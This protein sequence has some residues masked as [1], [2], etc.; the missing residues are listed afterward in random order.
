MDK[1]KRFVSFLL[2]FVMILGF[3]PV[4]AFATDTAA[5]TR[6]AID[7]AVFF[8][9]LHINNKQ[10]ETDSKKTL[11]TDVLTAIKNAD[12]P[13]STVNSS[14]DMYSSNASNEMV[15]GNASQVTGWIN[16][17][18]S[19][20]ETNYVW[21]DHDRAATDISK[22]SYMVDYDNYY[23]YVLSMGDLSSNDRYSTG[24]AYTKN[25]NTNRVKSGFSEGVFE[26]IAEFEADVSKLDK[27]K[28]LFI[29]GHQ[30]L[31]DNRNDNA[32]AE[33]WVEAINKVA[34]EMDVTYFFGHNHKYDLS[35][36]QTNG[37]DYYFAKGTKMPVPEWDDWTKA[38]NGDYFYN[39]GTQNG[40]PDLGY[41][42]VEIN[43]TH[44]CAGYMNP[45][46]TKSYDSKTSRLGTAVVAAIYD[47]CITYTVYDKD[48]VYDSNAKMALDVTVER[49]NK[50]T[51]DG[52]GSGETTEP[53]VTVEPV[54]DIFDSGISVAASG[55]TEVA[56]QE[57]LASEYDATRYTAYASYNIEVDGGYVE[58]TEA[59]VTIPAPVGFDVKKAVVVLDMDR[60]GKVIATTNIVDGKITFT[61][62][63]FSTYD[64]AQL[65]E[66]VEPSVLLNGWHLV[67]TTP[68]D[69][70][71]TYNAGWITFQ[72]YVPEVPATEKNKYVLDSDGVDTNV[73]YLIV[74]TGTNGSG[75]A[76]TNSSGKAA[77]TVVEIANGEILVNKSET[78]N[79]VWRFSG[80]TSGNVSNGG[81][82]LNPQNSSLSLSTS[83]TSSTSLTF[84]SQK[85][86][87]YRIYRLDGG[88]VR[89]TYYWISYDAAN[90]KWT[91]NSASVYHLLGSNS[92]I[93]TAMTSVHL[94][95]Y[96]STVTTEH[97]PAVP[98]LYGKIAIADN[99]DMSVTVEHGT[100]ME[101]AIA[102]LQAKV[103][104]A[105]KTSPD[106]TV[107]TCADSD[108]VWTID[109][110]Y[111]GTVGGD[112]A[113][114]ISYN[115]VTLGIGEVV[116]ESV[117]AY[118]GA[119][120]PKNITVEMGTSAGMAL[121][122][123]KQAVTIYSATTSNGDNSTPISDSSVTWEWVDEYNASRPGPY[124][125]EIKAGDNL[126][127]EV[128]VHVHVSYGEDEGESNEVEVGDVTIIEKTVYMLTNELVDGEEYLIVNKKTEGS[129]YALQNNNNNNGS[130]ASTSVDVNVDSNGTYIELDNADAVLWTAT[131]SGNTWAFKNGSYYLN[132]K[133]STSSSIGITTYSYSLELNGSSANWTVSDNQVYANLF[134]QDGWWSDEYDDY[135]LTGGSSWSMSRNSANVYFYIP[136]PIT[137]IEGEGVTYT[138]SASDLEHYV[139][140]DSKEAKLSYALLANGNVADPLPGSADG[141]DFKPVNDKDNIIDHIDAD[142]TIHFTGATGSALVRVSYTLDDGRQVYKYVTVTTTAPDN[143]PQYSNEGAVKVN[144]TGSAVGNFQSTGIAQVEISAS[145]VPKD[146]GMDIILML[147][148]SSSMQR[149]ITCGYKSNGCTGD[150][151]NT[152][153]PHSFVSRFDELKE[154][155]GDLEDV[156]KA[157]PNADIKI[158][159]ADFNGF[160][161]SGPYARDTD[162][163][164]SDDTVLNATGKG[165]V[166]NPATG[167]TCEIGANA[168]VSVDKIDFDKIIANTSAFAPS[169]GTNYDY[170]FDVIYQLGHAIKKANG[171]NQREL[172]VIFMSDG[173]PNQYNY[174]HSIGSETASEDESYKWNKWLQGTFASSD[175]TTSNLKSDTHKHYY[176]LKDHD[177][178]GYI[179]E[180]RMA[181]AIKGDP[182][183][184][185]E[186]VR[187]SNEGLTD[188][189][190]T[191]NSNNLYEIPGLGATMYSVGFYIKNDGKITAKSVHHV[192]E[193]IANTP[194]KY[195]T[196]S[197]AGALSKVFTNIST[198][199]IYSAYNARY[200][201]QMGK[202][203]DLQMKPLTDLDG[204]L[205]D[206]QHPNSR[207]EVIEYDVYTRADF[208]SG[209][210]TEDQIGD[211]KGTKKVLETV[212]FEYELTTGANGEEVYTV[213][214][215]YS[216]VIGNKNI[217]G[218][219]GII[220]AKNFY[221]N[222]TSKPV[223]I[224]GLEIPTGVDEHNLTT[225]STNILPA[226]SFYWGLGTLK[227]TELALR[228][229]VYLTGSMEGTRAAGTYPTNTYANL[230]Y[231]NH[232]GNPC[233]KDTV[234]PVMP[235]KEATVS[236][237]FYL[238]DENG[239]IIVNQ[240]TGDIG[241]FANKVA[242]TNPVQYST[243]KLNADGSID[244]AQ[245]AA[246]GVLPEGYVLYDAVYDANGNVLSG[247][248]Y[249][250]AVDSDGSGSWVITGPKDDDTT[251]VTQFD[252][253]NSTAY[254]NA[255]NYGQ[256]G[257]DY[258]H[259]VVW[260]AVVWKIQPL[261]DTVV[262]DYGLPVDIS[263][264]VNDMFGTNGKLA[265]VGKLD[266]PG[267]D[268]D[269]HTATNVLST[270]PCELTYGIAT[271]NTA[272]GKVRYSLNSM[273]M[274][275]H[276]QF[277]Y[278]VQYTGSENAG[279]YYETVTVIP[280][281]T[282][283]YEDSFM[284]YESF[285]W[286]GNDW[287]AFVPKDVNGDD[288]VDDSLWSVQGTTQDAVQ[289]EDR[290]G[291]YA[292]T[293]A[294]NIY[295]YDGVN[296]NMSTFS[297]GSAHKATVDG[298]NYASAEFSFYGTGFDIISMTDSTTGTILVDI[299]KENENGGWDEF[300]FYAVDTYYGY[301]Y[302]DCHVAYS[303]DACEWDSD[304]NPTAFKWVRTAIYHATSECTDKCAKQIVEQK[305]D[306]PKEYQ[307]VHMVEGAWV[308]CATEN[309][310]YQ[311]P[312]IKM[313]N[314]D[315]GHY[316]V[317]IKALYDIFFD[318]GKPAD[319][320]Y[321]FYLDAIRI[322][323]PAN[324]GAG[325]SVIEEAYKADH[326]GW[327]SYI[328]LRNGLIAAGSFD[329]VAN[330]V[331]DP[332]Q[333]MTGLVFI[334]G[335]S[336]LGNEQIADYTSYGPNNEVYIAPGQRVAFLLDTPENIDKVHI[337]LSVATAGTTAT[338]TITNI[339]L[340]DNADGK[341]TG[342]YYNYK[343]FKLDTATDMY[344][345]LTDWKGDIIVIS[346][347]GN[348]AEN[349]TTGVI[350]VTNIKS[351][352]KTNP[353]GND[354]GVVAP[355][356][357][358]ENTTE[359]ESQNLTRIYMTPKA[360]DV[361]LET[362]NDQK[363]VQ[364]PEVPVV[365]EEPEVPE[366]TEVFE[367][368]MVH[369]KLNKDEIK[370]GQ[371]VL[372]TVTTS[373]DVEYV[374]INGEKITKFSGG[375]SGNRTWKLNVVGERVGNMTVE[376]VC[377]N[378]KGIE[379][380]VLTAKVKVKAKNLVGF[381]GDI[382]G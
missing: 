112:Y 232:A 10:E 356:K 23:V 298:N 138:M 194:D 56:V 91:G 31:F 374:I 28:P 163:H 79:M 165:S 299:Y 167:A 177:G 342:D 254:S 324:D 183:K 142:G 338:Y 367:P 279:Y 128:E 134:Y 58:D 286:A 282:I 99:S 331:L 105:Y 349:E 211:R 171:D 78:A 275:T 38:G 323:D 322:Y 277:A 257:K 369:V 26:A 19:D 59:V 63:H 24:F 296:L 197:D 321:D 352:Y 334:D 207:I 258:T 185:Y 150:D 110:N 346:N 288:K 267:I 355:E 149:C 239:N 113:V 381:V 245:I 160:Y 16:S 125:V 312:V 307:V 66:T 347:T 111:S 295:G 253:S 265:G 268:M 250:V 141:Y 50:A 169:S 187:K 4:N 221:Y 39:S 166:Y 272:T 332:D 260:F 305:P 154:A 302:A 202:D 326:E 193:Q 54:Y 195:I 325:N 361:V 1:M 97:V 123:V 60:G 269:G 306:E 7:A 218:T 51:G 371:K 94:Y 345:D 126:L 157:S 21:T 151:R 316:R 243:I 22:K 175:L 192:L 196:A 34:E 210:C 86:G 132:R 181:N 27:S 212:T 314:K 238:V 263:V 119:M 170:A 377:G 284:K 9:D 161:T 35:K 92:S 159:V 14:G 103:D 75:S 73:D 224:E 340:M 261:P 311:V 228:Y 219:D 53:E 188:I 118:Y 84:N 77:G 379:S 233:H 271:V 68:A 375:N 172:V 330:E 255:E 70:V 96:H 52:T 353:N 365:P 215:A 293:D 318:H 376:V 69:D 43:F 120:G 248:T 12:Y 237:A 121:T 289:G 199:L 370:V 115:G 156:L 114:T 65:A 348:R 382:F 309:S 287:G 131:G 231:D 327:P 20:A 223:A 276:E 214:G 153:N 264:L 136:T 107:Q 8:S 57:I 124:T 33:Y 3:L 281:T 343:T 18:F 236:Y 225:G 300:D 85:T 64:V 83:S 95:K 198:D 72:E 226:E 62:T 48:G 5:T 148:M 360:A 15:T 235:W 47:D 333:Q 30:P 98:G 173:A 357:P 262:V 17:V 76:L 29:V 122:A 315:Y 102:A 32:W 362:L 244:T 88:L 67:S 329:D 313:A 145:G 87:A 6:D 40:N 42:M 106:G 217:L 200:V 317:T 104:V 290:P 205:L 234:S 283:Y 251:Y 2:C 180:H 147:D 310:I 139:T 176:D 320:K 162:D 252:P 133:S 242:V 378:S 247:A 190:P 280:A 168:F 100:S 140:K 49:K 273:E 304:G 363:N 164:M 259:T 240:T 179:N 266:A 129:A 292:L 184:T 285:T 191:T 11:L 366:I 36:D 227:T 44:I 380:E 178:D 90:A 328:E 294:N 109:P 116:V 301:T 144:K 37:Q 208:L 335:K 158:A 241:S 339:A 201:D 25:N 341:K 303:Y 206:P 137:I 354:T 174:Y 364:T 186:V 182:N 222:T 336:A 71:T 213:T 291:Q 61:T 230:Y 249:T 216:D 135:Y 203:Y 74:N 246:S 368:K 82:Y 130:V 373:A 152:T 372:V 80:T 55:I 350:S 359:P 108:V 81:Y 13:V 344:Y 319:G 155:M 204:N 146:S 189:I 89:D 358:D 220:R 308:P 297:L 337:G 101:A 41:N 117:D 274:K 93:P 351:T 46:T 127:G 278:S 143:Y 45:E 209:K 256:T 270:E 229:Y